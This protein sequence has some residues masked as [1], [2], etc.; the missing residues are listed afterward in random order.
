MQ[1]MTN[2]EAVADVLAGYPAALRAV[3]VMPTCNV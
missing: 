2:L 1:V 3:S